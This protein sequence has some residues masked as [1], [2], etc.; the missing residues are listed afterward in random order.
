MT[1][2]PF[3]NQIILSSVEAEDKNN[4]QT[5][6]VPDAAKKDNNR[7]VV[8]AI[9]PKVNLSSD[10]TIVVGDILVYRPHSGIAIEDNGKKYLSIS[11]DAVIAL[12]EE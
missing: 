6:I 8:V 12:V 5:I 4:T 9:G 7:G 10:R 11:M 3:G 1:L 2:L